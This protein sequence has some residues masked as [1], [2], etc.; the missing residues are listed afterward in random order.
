MGTQRPPEITT[1]VTSRGFE[2]VPL[3]VSL[4]RWRHEKRDRKRRSWGPPWGK[5]NLDIHRAGNKA[6]QERQCRSLTKGG[7]R[8]AINKHTVSLHGWSQSSRPTISSWRYSGLRWSCEMYHLQD[9][10]PFI[11]HRKDGCLERV[12]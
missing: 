1:Q 8:G 3:Q 9:T 10:L 7:R 5:T 4:K 6:P 2:R 11:Y 12:N